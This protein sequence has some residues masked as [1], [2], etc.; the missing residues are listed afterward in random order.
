GF[1]LYGD[2][3]AGYFPAPG[4]DGTSSPRLVWLACGTEDFLIE[5]H[6]KFESW[7]KEKGVQFTSKEM[8]GPTPGWSGGAT[9]PTWRPCC[10]ATHSPESMPHSP[11]SP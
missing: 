9:W 11:E 7:L 10:S 2:D 5:P 1:I 3:Y 8:P 6:R 4:G